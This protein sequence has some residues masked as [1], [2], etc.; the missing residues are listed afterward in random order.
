VTEYNARFGVDLEQIEC[1]ETVR[2]VELAHNCCVH[3]AW[4]SELKRALQKE[5]RPLMD[6]LKSSL[7]NFVYAFLLE[8][9]GGTA[10]MAHRSS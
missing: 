3:R 4:R 10:F 8:S 7:C 6:R 1:F 9:G 2:E 5:S